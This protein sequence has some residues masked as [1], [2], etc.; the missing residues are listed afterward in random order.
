LESLS[1]QF[2]G[3]DLYQIP[4]VSH[5]MVLTLIS[6]L[7]QSGIDKFANSQAFSS[8]SGTAPNQAI[9]GGKKLPYKKSFKSSCR[10][11]KAFLHSANTIGNSKTGY[12][13]S[14]HS[15]ISYRL[16]R[17]AANKAV[18]RKLSVIVYHMLSKK[19]AYKPVDVAERKAKMR[20]KNIKIIQSKLKKYDIKLE[21]IECV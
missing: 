1:Y 3:V 10:L 5:Q 8:Y 13:K 2:F 16:G 7:G 18:A 11:N 21:E 14:F 6:E 19:E 20:S 4:G 9:S 12:L 15:K 17:T